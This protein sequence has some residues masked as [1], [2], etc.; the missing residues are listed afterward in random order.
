MKTILLLSSLALSTVATH[1]FHHAIRAR[2]SFSSSSSKLHC[3]CVN[4]KYVTDCAAYHFVEEKHEQ[5]HIS[6]DPTFEPRDGSPTINVHM[7]PI[8]GRQEEEQKMQQEHKTEEKKAMANNDA[9]AGSG[10]LIGET[11]YDMRPEMSL[12]Y[13]VVVCEDFV[14]DKGCWVRNMPEE[15][16]IANPD[17]VPP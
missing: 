3:I 7:R 13:D 15:I 11:V 17:F 2:A 12:E 1:A 6:A 10:V 4:C 8:V 14:E 16:R 5:P 9:A